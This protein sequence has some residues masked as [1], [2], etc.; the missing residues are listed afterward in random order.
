MIYILLYVNVS[1]IICHYHIVIISHYYYVINSIYSI[2]VQ[3]IQKG[4]FYIYLYK[5]TLQSIL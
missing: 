2:I 5:S 4:T 3:F 1:Y